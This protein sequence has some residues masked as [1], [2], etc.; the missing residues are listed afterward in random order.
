MI[1]KIQS[2][3]KT[4]F[5]ICDSV[6]LDSGITVP[7]ITGQCSE[8]EVIS[9][10]G[11]RY[12]NGFWDKVVNDPLVQQKVADR[13]FLGTIEHPE[14]DNEYL[15]T[16]YNKAS[17]V[18][19]KLWVDNNNPFAVIGLLNNPEGNAIKALIDVG[20]RPGISTRGLGNFCKDSVS[21]YVD[22]NN[23]V[24]LGFDVVKNANFASLKMDK[25]SD[26]LK[27]SPLFKELMEMHHLKDSAEE[28]YDKDSLIKE[29][30]S[31]ITELQRKYQLLL[32]L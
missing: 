31:A 28:H 2:V 20:H 14:D 13:E 27:D 22:E 17:H 26:S 29:M 4:R 3:R 1:N 7:C 11:Y 15:R 12:R 8:S 21:Q 16:S 5:K 25:V 6:Q 30:G 9:Q 10:N 24:F 18:L 19:F 23:Y 32:T